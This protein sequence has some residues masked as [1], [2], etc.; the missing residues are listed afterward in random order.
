VLLAALLV[1]QPA[2]LLLALHADVC[3]SCASAQQQ[4]QQL[5]QEL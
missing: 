5:Q 3:M 2:L 1:L 4:Q